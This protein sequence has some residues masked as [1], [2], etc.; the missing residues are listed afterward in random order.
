[1]KL[2]R[3]AGASTIVLALAF[4]AGLA[5]AQANQA[6]DRFRGRADQLQR[7]LGDVASGLE[8][9][10]EKD[11]VRAATR[12]YAL[13]RATIDLIGMASQVPWAKPGDAGAAQAA[14]RAQLYRIYQL[15]ERVQQ[16][17]IQEL[18]RVLPGEPER[19]N[20]AREERD[21]Y[22]PLYRLGT[23][24][25][26]ERRR[27]PKQALQ[28][29]KDKYAAG[30]GQPTD[31]RFLGK[32][33]LKKLGSGQLA[34]WVQFGSDRFRMN[35][36]GAKHPVIGQGKSV[37]GAGS[38][39][40]YKDQTGNVV[41]AVVSNSSGNYKPG[42]GSTEG[43]VQRLMELGVNPAHILVTSIIPEEPEL[44]KL[45]LKSKLTLNEDQVKEQVKLVRARAA[46]PPRP[47]AARMPRMRS[48]RLVR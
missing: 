25:P 10:L 27:T 37:R 34:E 38:M 7:E 6:T 19:E 4:A 18:D 43:P 9:E 44:V 1:M 32:T 46:P 2:T 30:G 15:Q 23:P 42:P 40:I 26:G 47:P 36:A 12:L 24:K 28:E 31:F 39:K 21:L 13:E 41:L 22:R 48:A 11:D 45:L 3:A 29:M 35:T 5:R 20:W 8:H 14:L 33:S 16:H 17:A